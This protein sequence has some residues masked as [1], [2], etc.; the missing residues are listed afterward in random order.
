[1]INLMQNPS[2]RALIVAGLGL[3]FTACMAENSLPQVQKNTVNQ[4]TTPKYASAY[5]PHNRTSSPYVLMAQNNA[6]PHLRGIAQNPRNVQRAY[7]QDYPTQSQN[8]YG[9]A[10]RVMGHNITK[11]NFSHHLDAPRVHQSKRL[12]H[13]LDEGMTPRGYYVQ[14][15]QSRTSLNQYQRASL[16]QSAQQSAQASVVARANSATRVTNAA[17][18]R[19]SVS[20][21]S[22]N[23]IHNSLINARGES[24]RLAI[25]NLR[26]QEAEEG[27][28]QAEALSKVRLNFDSTIGV[29]QSETEFNV[30]ERTDADTRLRRAA[31]IDLSLPIY[32]GGINKAQKNVAKVGIK[33]AEANY[34]IVESA[35]TEEAAI[36]HLNVIRDRKLIQAY[37]RNVDLL[38]NQKQNVQAM[39]RAGENTVT[40]EALIDARLASIEVRLEQ[41]KANLAISESNY[42]KLTGSQASS[43]VTVGAVK[44]P[45]SLQEI[46]VAAQKNNAQIKAGETQAEAAFH[47]IAVAKSYGRP[48]LSLQG[49]LRTAEGQSETISRDSA[50]EL[51]LNLNVPLLS[52]GENKSRVRQAVLAQ[53]RAFLET[54]ELHDNLNERVEQLWASV[55][56][57]RRS[58]AP[59][60]AQKVAAQKAYEAITKQRNAGLATS[61]DVLSVEQTLL[62]AEIN[63]LQAQNSEDVARFQ[64]LGL[65]GAL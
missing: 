9:S 49:V 7:Y 42:K 6:V 15:T 44:L 2:V 64:I 37:T 57:A 60:Q 19:S 17:T 10:R 21:V 48:K 29:S 20:T 45:S 18:T 32:Q 23:S 31:R 28:V 33:T 11:Q 43:L 39:V 14:K 8:Q 62:D 12:N 59:N 5:Q 26:I 22:P 50:A 41:S 55:Q 25:E 24:P 1:M 51:L 3:S 16:V 35:V 58:K 30:I 52:G 40:D 36:A 34:E 65:M 54:R 13:H 38:R 61:L 47:N 63:L 56:S 46:K 27:L 53:S 4:V